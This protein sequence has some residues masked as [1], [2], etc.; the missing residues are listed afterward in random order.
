M[1]HLFTGLDQLSIFKFSLLKKYKTIYLKIMV[2]TIPKII[3]YFLF[4]R[5]EMNLYMKEYIYRTI[6]ALFSGI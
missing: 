2:K 1:E 5:M 3:H 4:F 6:T